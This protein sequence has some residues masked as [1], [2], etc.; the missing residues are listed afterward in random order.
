M[1]KLASSFANRR[2]NDIIKNGV[3]LLVVIG[4]MY[5]AETAD[6]VNF[7][8]SLGLFQYPNPD[9]DSKL[10]EV[11]KLVNASQTGAVCLD[12]SVPAIHFSEGFESGTDNWLIHLEG[13]GQC[14]SLEEC[15]GRTTNE[16][17]SSNFMTPMGFAGILS[18]NKSRNPEFYN[19]NRVKVRY[20]DGAFFAGSAS[21]ENEASK[22]KGLFFRGQ[23]IWDVVMTELL[24]LGMANAKQAFLTGCSAGGLATLLHCDSFAELFTPGKVNVKC[25]SDAGF[26][27]DEKDFS[28]A[29][30]VES[31]YHDVVTLQGMEANLNKECISQLKPSPESQCLFP[32]NFIN[33]IKT[34]VFLVNPIYDAVQM[35][36][37]YIPPSLLNDWYPACAFNYANCTKALIKELQ[38]FAGFRG[39][40]LKA[41]SQ[42]QGKKDMGM[43]IDPCFAHCQ[44]DT[45]K[46]HLRSPKINDKTIAEAVGDWYFNRKTVQYI[47]DRALSANPT[48]NNKVYESKLERLLH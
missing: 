17:G 37:F 45:D 42:Y 30:K 22:A 2:T 4:I 3:R 39:S 9:A 47:D 7:D 5:T 43:F 21:G 18:R 23:L 11:T 13:G 35:S 46:W 48:C 1:G 44:T 41:L 16:T 24:G 27:I 29:N 12:G 34:P 15:A 10:I 19:W 6:A 40:M 26:F 32:Q 31:V 38:D 33:N 25:L 14:S 36:L 20:C 28:G 8:L